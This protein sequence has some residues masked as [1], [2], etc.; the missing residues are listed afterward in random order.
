[1]EFAERGIRETFPEANVPTSI[2]TG[3]APVRQGHASEAG[4]ILAQ[5]LETAVDGSACVIAPPG[6]SP[7]GIPV[8][9]RIRVLTP[10]LV[11]GLEFDLVLIMDPAGFGGGTEGS[12]DRYVAMTRATR[13]LVVLTGR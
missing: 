11:K 2:R 6:Q 1:M 7:V 9:P 10:D 3:G 12:V 13:E 8:D 5:W 4:P